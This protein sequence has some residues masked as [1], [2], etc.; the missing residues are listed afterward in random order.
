MPTQDQIKSLKG[1]LVEFY[2][3]QKKHYKGYQA[4]LEFVEES[5]KDLLTRRTFKMS[6]TL[7]K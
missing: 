3:F 7:I 6:F 5:L 1:L 4:I 2:K